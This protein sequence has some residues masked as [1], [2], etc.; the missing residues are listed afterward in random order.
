MATV[1]IVTVAVGRAYQAFLPEWAASVAELDRQPDR[2]VIVVD[3]LSVVLR[4]QIRVLLPNVEVVRNATRWRHHPQVLVNKAIQALDTDWVC[5]LDVDDLILP[6]AFNT[7]DDWSADVRMFGIRLL[8]GREACPPLLTADQILNSRH[9]LLYAA[10]PFRRSVWTRTSGFRDM[11]FDDWAFWREVA[12]Q[13]ATF[14]PSGQ[15]D[16]FYRQHDK[17]ATSHCDESIE[18]AKV[19]EVTG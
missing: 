8:G 14:E 18:R 17:S 6:H 5:K 11:V 2:V 1:A 12:A 4:R 13:G 10:S 16:Y 3:S 9:N 19:F 15:P 7:L